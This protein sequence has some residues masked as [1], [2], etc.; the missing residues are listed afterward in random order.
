MK[1]DVL[2]AIAAIIQESIPEIQLR[3]DVSKRGMRTAFMT[4]PSPTVG[5][6]CL[7]NR[8]LHYRVRLLPKGVII[9]N[10][11][12]ETHRQNERVLTR[13][14]VDP[15]DP[16]CFDK[17]IKFISR[18]KEM[19][20][21]M[22]VEA[23]IETLRETTSFQVYRHDNTINIINIINRGSSGYPQIFTAILI[24]HESKNGSIKLT[25]STNINYSKESLRVITCDLADPKCFD[26][27]K[28]SLEGWGQ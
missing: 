8:G 10:V 28:T 20:T 22:I 21:C 4:I 9:Y 1:D 24:I 15:N 16:T 3:M 23:I 2:Q 6:H 17:L 11:E 13:K 27:I 14:M 12:F 5:L 7:D 25:L 19:R 26:I 18:H